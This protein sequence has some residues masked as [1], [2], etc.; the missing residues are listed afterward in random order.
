[1]VKLLC[2]TLAIARMSD[3]CDKPQPVAPTGSGTGSAVVANDTEPPR[4]HARSST[5]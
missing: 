5:S 3:G 2:I 1:M 4:P